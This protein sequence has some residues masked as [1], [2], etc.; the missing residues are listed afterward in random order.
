VFCAA[1]GSLAVLVLLSAW[2]SCTAPGTKVPEEVLKT[3]EHVK[4]ALS[5]DPRLDLFDVSVVRSGKRLVLRGELI[6]PEV[7]R[8]LLD[9]L[10][11]YAGKFD[12]VDSIAVLPEKQL[13][14]ITWGIVNV[15]VANMRKEPK[16]QAELVNQTLLGTVVR[17]YKV[18]NRHY[19]IQNWDRYLGWVSGASLTKMDSIR[20]A[21][22]VRAP[23]LIVV[24][25]D[26]VRKRPSEQAETLV[27]LVPGCQLVKIAGAGRYVRVKLPDNRVGYVRRESVLTMEEFSRRKATP[28]SIVKTAKQF[29]GTP[30]L[31]GG[32]STFGFDCSGFVQTV[33]RLNNFELPRD[34]NQ[35]VNIE[36][37]VVK[38]DAMMKNFKPG[39]MLFF[40]PKP[41]RITHVAISLGGQLYIHSDGDVHISS[42]DPF[43]PIYSPYRHETFQIAK[44]IFEK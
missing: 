11:R 40:G 37:K 16:H 30:Y 38:P 41:N 31:W 9:S 42:F 29:L 7:H 6:R 12:I 27:R 28:E 24:K 14:S 33:F 23:R 18:R 26:R 22:W 34:A 19:F 10:K 4:K 13:F 1:T 36:G 21:L 25:E 2:L 39:D 44:R 32:T 20:A 8:V 3:V 43:S 15:A 17:L 35:M 5:P